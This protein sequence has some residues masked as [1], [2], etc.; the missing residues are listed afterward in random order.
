MKVF[1]F[2]VAILALLL[3]MIIG[4]GFY[5]RSVTKEVQDDLEALPPCQNAQ[6][7]VQALLAYWRGKEKLLELSVS[8]ADMNE[9]DNHLAELSVAARLNDE[10]AFERARTLCLCGIARIHELE[11]FSFLHIL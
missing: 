2:S 1:L 11:R 3:A 8:A 4:N 5:V 6:E 7:E 9:F 10:K